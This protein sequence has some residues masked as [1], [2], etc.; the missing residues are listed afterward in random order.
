MPGRRSTAVRLVVLPDIHVP[1]HDMPMVEYA[2][3]DCRGADHVVVLGD[4]L[5]AY[6][7]MSHLKNPARQHRLTDEVDQA[8]EIISLLRSSARRARIDFIEGNHEDRLRRYVWAKAPDLM[9]L[10]PSIPSLLGLDEAGINHHPQSGF[11]AYGCRF[12]HGSV[13][14]AQSAYTAR[15]EMLRHRTSG[16][17]GHTHRMGMTMHTDSEGTTTEWWECGHLLDT[18]NAEYVTNPDWQPGYVVVE[19]RH[20]GSIHVTPIRL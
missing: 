16:F 3:G 4:L 8:K 12:K 2:I 1:Y 20:D 18:R 13:V 19:V 9:G 14:R 17:S 5:D 11:V 6:P 10:V 15:S 7:L